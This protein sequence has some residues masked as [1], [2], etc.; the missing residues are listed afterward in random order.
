MMLQISELSPLTK[1][2][3]H[4]RQFSAPS[5]T[6]QAPVS[7]ARGVYVASYLPRLSN[8]NLCVCT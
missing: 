1:C 7:I 3:P 2:S 5:S 4:C 6:M 8:G